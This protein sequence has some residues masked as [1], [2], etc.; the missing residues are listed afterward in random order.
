MHK[1]I[2][3]AQI[4]TA[5][6]H[7]LA[8]LERMTYSGDTAGYDMTLAAEVSR[9]GAAAFDEAALQANYLRMPALVEHCQRNAR[10]LRQGADMY[11]R[12]IA[13]TKRA[14]SE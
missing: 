2:E 3:I 12:A 9:L 14:Y 11:E 5:A 7:Y 6:A 1:S 10:T 8:M 13:H 4:L